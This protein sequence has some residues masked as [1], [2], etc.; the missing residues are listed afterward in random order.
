MPSI[1]IDAPHGNA[2]ICS[3]ETAAD[4]SPSRRTVSIGQQNGA[5]LK[6]YTLTR[7]SALKR[8][9]EPHGKACIR[10]G[11]G[12]VIEKRP[13]GYPGARGSIGLSVDG[14][15]PAIILAG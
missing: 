11:T 14:C 10:G 9:V 3:A 1:G 2:V 12:V 8:S 6:C 5:S 15:D 7:I 4:Y 13:V